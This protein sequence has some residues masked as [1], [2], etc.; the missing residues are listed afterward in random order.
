ML[1]FLTKISKIKEEQFQLRKPTSKVIVHNTMVAANCFYL[2]T[3]I[4]IPVRPL[5]EA[6]ESEEGEMLFI[7]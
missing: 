7:P 2:F 6:F 4:G 3:S 5:I 1:K